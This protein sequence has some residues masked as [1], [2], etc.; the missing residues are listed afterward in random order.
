MNY[1]SNEH[2]GHRTMKEKTF[3]LLINNL[4]DTL[5][6]Y[7]SER[8][9]KRGKDS[10]LKADL[11]FETD[12]SIILVEIKTEKNREGLLQLLHQS[13]NIQTDKKIKLILV[14]N[15]IGKRELRNFAEGLS[16]EELKMYR[17]IIFDK[18]FKTFKCINNFLGYKK[19][20]NHSLINSLFSAKKP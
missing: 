10:W 2:I 13:Q 7:D 20:I 16:D 14:C 8:Y 9:I 4:G 12:T 18:E 6:Q 17:C 15:S 5:I 1:S 11:Y 3:Q 19:K